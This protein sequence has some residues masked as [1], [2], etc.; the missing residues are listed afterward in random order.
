MTVVPCPT[1]AAE[2]PAGAKFCPACGQPTTVSR[3][4]AE[5]RVVSVVFADL[6]GFTAMAEGRDPEAVKELL[7][8]CFGRLVPI[9]EHYGGQVDKI[10]GDELMAVFGA[11]IAHEDDPERAVRAAL[12]LSGPLGALAPGLVLRVGINTG[13]VL[14]GPVGPSGAYTVTGDTVNTAHRLVSVAEPG[15]V[16]VGERTRGASAEAVEYQERPLYRLRGKQSPVRAWAAVGVRSGPGRGAPM[17]VTSPMVGRQREMDQL[18]AAVA[19]AFG[20]RAPA[21]VLVTGEPGIG[22]T[23]LALELHLA[24]WSDRPVG[25]FLWAACPPYGASSSLGPLAELVRAG[26]GVDA[27]AARSRQVTTVRDRVGPIAEATEADRA[28]LTARVGQLLGLHD[29]PSRATETDPGPTRARVVDELVGAA[30]L[31]LAGLA[32][33]APTL[34]V[35]DD[36]QW[37][38]GAGRGFL[39]RAA[40]R[41]TDAPLLVLALGRDEVLERRP[42]LATG[43]VRTISLPPLHPDAG[44]E[45]LSLLLHDALTGEPDGRWSGDEGV[46][47]GRR[48]AGELGPDAEKRI[49]AAA[50]GNPF[51][52]EELVRYLDDIGAIARVD[53]QWQATV[54]LDTVG[55]PDGVRSLI[56]ARLDALPPEERGFLTDAAIVGREFWQAAVTAID[57]YEHADHLVT[58]LVTRGLI[59]PL[60]EDVQADLAFRH[61]LTADVA[62]ASVPIGERALKHAKVAGWLRRRF[63]P[64][65]ESEVVGLLAH[66]YERAVTLS[67]EL[68]HTD[69]GLTGAAFAALVRAAQEAERHDALRDADH[70]YRRARNLGTFDHDAATRAELEHGMVLVDLRRLD[71]AAAAFTAVATAAG[72]AQPALGARAVTRLGVVAR[73][74]G[75]G[76][77]ARQHFDAGREAWRAL[78]DPAG[79]A[80]TLRL[81]GWAE[82]MAG[83]ARAAL[84]SLERA[85]ALERSPD[86]GGE[87]GETLQCLGWCEFLV[88]DIPD[89]RTHLWEAAGRLGDSGDVGGMGWCFGILGFSFL[90]EG[91]ISRAKEIA[92]NLLHLARAQGDPWAEGTCTVL[93]AACQIEGGAP[94]DAEP[95]L[96]EA[97]RIFGELDY[98]WGEAMVNL[99]AGQHART[100]GA[101]DRARTA[102]RAGLGTARHVTY[103]G[104][105]SRLLAE[106]AGL[107]A[108]AGEVEEAERRARAALALVRAG[109]G[110]ADSELRALIVLG[111]LA[112]RRGDRAAAQLLLE[113]AIS[114]QEPSGATSAWRR[115]HAHPALLLASRGASVEAQRAAE[116]AVDGGEES[117]RTRVLVQRALA[118]VAVGE[119]RP[120]EARRLLTA[121]VEQWS[122]RSLAFLAPVSE[123][124]A[125]LDGPAGAGGA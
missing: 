68:E 23:L 38:D 121:T 6:A 73:L 14:A 66:H 2:L 26:L 110:D 64:D 84:P 61:V 103:V 44:K 95:L 24:L 119:G 120:A 22:K 97:A 50:G 8:Q 9:I 89:A 108:D 10:I 75:D 100:V 101:I 63:S 1:C 57:D 76:D 28:L 96:A 90:Q 42:G 71:E 105:E 99:A 104:E 52:L 78:D 32:R 20:A 55:L 74:Q 116:V 114:L 88:G 102:L 83:R 125:A 40:G 92:D 72:S 27:E 34:V 17:R 11:P 39:E 29:L 118:A 81:Q 25:H 53:V 62:Y 70:W 107:E 117:V 41:L 51:L 54:D 94:A 43:A 48:P 58:Q 3:T 77:Q 37:A 115:A 21:V 59:E 86:A 4:A 16:L 47:E 93:L 30:M 79:E 80:D 45:L 69:P 31:I 124:L 106:L 15:E 19:A 35:L 7:D 49:L 112:E 123:D 36:I 56:G 82:L 109:I 111:E 98:P 12:E 67:R 122:G 18:E 91:R 85:L 5:R 87:R 65:R 33:H 113:E 46:G 13:E 60:A